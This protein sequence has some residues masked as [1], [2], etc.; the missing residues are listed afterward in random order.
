MTEYHD[1]IT[2]FTRSVINNSSLYIIES[3]IGKSTLSFLQLSHKTDCYLEIYS[4]KYEQGHHNLYEIDLNLN[5]QHSFLVK[6]P[7]SNENT[8]KIDNISEILFNSDGLNQKF[9]SL[10][11]VFYSINNEMNHSDI[12]APYD[13]NSNTDPIEENTAGDPVCKTSYITG[14]ND[15]YLKI[16]FGIQNEENHDNFFA[17]SDSSD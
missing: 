1:Q 14:N 6:S 4:V 8:F 15:T 13:L 12:F 3:D 9:M 17:D 5:P 7:D 10:E 2:L 11:N 16:Y